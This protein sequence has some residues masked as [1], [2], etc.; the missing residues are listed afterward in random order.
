MIWSGM[1]R[2]FIS[3]GTL[4]LANQ[5]SALSCTEPMTISDHN[6]EVNP[7]TLRSFIHPSGSAAATWVSS[8]QKKEVV[9]LSYR[10]E[11]SSWS[12][13]EIVS[14]AEN[15]IFWSDAYIHN[16]GDLSVA[17]KGDDFQVQFSEKKGEGAWIDPTRWVTRPKQAFYD[18]K[19]DVVGNLVAIGRSVQKSW[20]SSIESVAIFKQSLDYQS[21]Q[22]DLSS[23]ETATELVPIQFTNHENGVGYVCWVKTR[24]SH[25]IMVQKTRNY[26]FETDAEV[27]C[28]L[29]V[30]VNI[31]KVGMS[32]NSEGD[33]VI[34]YVDEKE[35]NGLI[36]TKYQD[37]W[38]KPFLFVKQEEGFSDIQL[39]L[40]AKGNVLVVSIVEMAGVS[41]LKSA[42][43]P[44]GRAWVT[45]DSIPLPN[46]DRWTPEVKADGNENFVLIWKEELNKRGALFGAL[47][48]TVNRAWAAPIRLSPY[49]ASCSNCSFGF[50]SPGKGY[51]FWEATING[52]DTHIQT[53]QLGD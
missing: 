9:T 2:K 42:Y 46:V 1:Y 40:D 43:K 30:G 31:H 25:A 17:W 20:I 38:A 48:S 18:V 49:E 13:P 10:R 12:M 28:K 22:E 29:D 4:L 44:F 50:Y 51:I 35:K 37:A 3:L 15:F 5:L 32:V 33:C 41:Y 47:F 8:S 53:A 26:R 36:V 11:N 52:F 45:L 14:K 24:P 16:N 19:F 23:D 39:G 7:Y 21:K 6:F 34:S 27:V